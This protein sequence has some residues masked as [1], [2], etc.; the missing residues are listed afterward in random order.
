MKIDSI[1][2][3]VN[4]KDLNVDVFA[5]LLIILTFIGF[6]IPTIY[7]YIPHG[8]DSYSHIFYTK[9]F[10]ETNSIDEF[11]NKLQNDY[12]T[13]TSYPFGFR[14][15]SSLVMKISSID[16]FSLSILQPLILLILSSLLYYLYS[17][18]LIPEKEP[19]IHAFSVLFMLSMPVITIGILNFETD[20]FMFPFIIL[21]FTLLLRD[22]AKSL[23]MMTI[24]LSL[25]PIFHAGTYLFIFSFLP[26]YIIVYSI[27]YNRVSKALLPFSAMLLSYVSFMRLFPEIKPQFGTKALFI[28]KIS[29]KIAETTGL[30]IFRAIGDAIYE[31]LF[32]EHSLINVFYAIIALYFLS[33]LA[34]KVSSFVKDKGMFSFAIAFA[35]VPKSPVFLPF[36]IGPLQTLLSLL[37][38]KRI[39][40]KVASILIPLLIIVLPSAMITGER[41]LREIQYLFLIVPILSTLGFLQVVETIKEKISNEKIRN[42]ALFLAFFS[43]FI[44]FGI[45]SVFGN[46]YYHPK[47]SIPPEDKFGLEWLGNVGSEKEGVGEIGYGHRVSVY[48]NKIPPSAVWIPAGKEMRRYLIDYSKAVVEGD[49]DAAKDLSSSFGAKYLVVSS[50][51][52]KG[53]KTSWK[54]I[55]LFDSESYDKILSSKEFAIA[56]FIEEKL[57]LSDIYPHIQFEDHP[58]IKDAGNF[59]LVETK[60]YKIRIG[61]TSPKIDY[62]GTKTENYLEEGSLLD[63]VILGKIKGVIIQGVEFSRVLLGENIV[64]Y[65]GEITKD[66]IPVATLIVRYT[67]Y[68]EAIKKEITVFNDYN[69]V[70][71]PIKI[72]TRFY[73]PYTHFTT[74]SES[75]ERFN[76]TIYPNEDYVLLRDLEFKEVFI[77]NDQKKGIYLSFEKTSPLPDRISYSG[78]TKHKGYSRIDFS[79][80]KDLTRVFPGEKVTVTQWISVGEEDEAKIR[81]ENSSFVNLHPHVKKPAILI[82][83]FKEDINDS[84]LQRI[85]NLNYPVVLSIPLYKQINIQKLKNYSSDNFQL[86]A[87]LKIKNDTIREEYYKN[88][89]NLSKFY[90]IKAIVDPYANLRSIKLFEEFGVKYVFN[91]YVSPP[92]LTL[93]D[94]GE[95]FPTIAVIRGKET[96]VTLLPISSPTLSA[97]SSEDGWRVVENI[98]RGVAGS[99]EVVILEVEDSVFYDNGSFKKL[100]RTIDFL[101][102]NGFEIVKLEK[103]REELVAMGKISVNVSGKYPEDFTVNIHSK[104]VLPEAKIL[105]KLPAEDFKISAENVKIEKQKNVI[106]AYLNTNSK[107]AK[108]HIRSS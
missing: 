99:D 7:L 46:A 37:S 17:K 26:A 102:K 32:S 67:F 76:R 84:I 55:N 86:A 12:F 61:K 93:F 88:L 65:R 47:I 52:L 45:V 48:A 69:N 16:A 98:A 97:E 21:I 54:E 5:I 34:T 25:L 73:A 31:G 11:Y 14:L 3:I 101:N 100:Q 58:T 22:D 82:V 108:I 20:S 106:K 91:K 42:T 38:L 15:F 23:L 75:G 83:K 72:T 8:T 30:G 78:S 13:K 6:V 90:P 87:Y 57:V 40:K 96:N 50:K 59:L 39:D 33:I 10:Y 74:L 4:I 70:R 64:E 107:T 66:Y 104:E 53:L 9:I 41:G 68:P 27:I 85:E 79:V 43:I 77:Y 105:I 62:L 19:K 24:L 44:S 92:Y 28:L 63:Y 94:E 36:W 56:R 18:E 89:P 81:I 1:R 95:R 71:V 49:T 60:S 29:D 2:K 51:T 35:T 103:V 80:K